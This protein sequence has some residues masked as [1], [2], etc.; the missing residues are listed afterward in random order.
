MY[1]RLTKL[2]KIDDRECVTCIHYGTKECRIH[3]GEVQNCSKCPILA[4]ALNQLYELENIVC[5]SV[6]DSETQK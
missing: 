5:E 1:T 2:T 3:S 4:A 6:A